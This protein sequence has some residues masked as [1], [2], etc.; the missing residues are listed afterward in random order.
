MIVKV[1]T[2][3]LRIPSLRSLSYLKLDRFSADQA[4]LA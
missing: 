4:D 2:K 1:C 3:A